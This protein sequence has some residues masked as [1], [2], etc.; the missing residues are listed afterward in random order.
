MFNNDTFALLSTTHLW[1]Q[2][3]GH[4]NYQNLLKIY[5]SIEGVEVKINQERHGTCH[6]CL[7]GKQT[8]QPFKDLVTRA[9]SLLE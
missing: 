4:I 5:N 1:H 3:M 9:S 7:Q 6:T 8:R 2:R